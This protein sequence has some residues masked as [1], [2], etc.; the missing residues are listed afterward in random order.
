MKIVS[1]KI[2]LVV[3]GRPIIHKYSCIFFISRIPSSEK[4][5]I[6]T[7]AT[8]TPLIYPHTPFNPTGVSAFQPSGTG[9]FK[10]TMPAS[11]KIVKSE[12]EEK[13][14]NNVVQIAPKPMDTKPVQGTQNSKPQ[15]ICNLPIVTLV[16]PTTHTI[17]WSDQSY[18]KFVCMSQNSFQIPISGLCKTLGNEFVRLEMLL[19]I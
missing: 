1:F 8:G 9:A 6:T 4:L 2:K 14:Q 13:L 15:Q 5:S 7:Q 17:C 10:T 18:T 12:V 11:P 3:D 19:L 16:N